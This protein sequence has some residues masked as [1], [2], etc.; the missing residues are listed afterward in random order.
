[1]PVLEKRRCPRPR[2]LLLA[3]SGALLLAGCKRPPAQT[4][5][6]AAAPT[7]GSTPAAPIAAAAGSAIPAPI[8]G[9][10]NVAFVYIG[11][12]GDGGWTY[13]HDQ[14]RQQL[15]KLVPDV[16][17]AY[18][19]S[20]AEGADAAQVIRGLA[21]KGFQLIV[22]TSFGY[23]DATEQVAREFPGTKFVHVSGFKSN[24]SNFGNLF[25]AM[26]SMKYLAGMIAGARAKADGRPRVGY[27]APFPIAEVIRLGNA[28]ALGVRASCPECTLTVRWIH[29]WFDP[30]R[31][32][33]AAESLLADG[34][35]VVVTGADS[36]GP[37]V[38]AAE[39]GRWGIGYDS[40]NACQAS[41]AR[42][43]TTPYWNW[44]AIYAD[45]VKQ[46]QAGTW[47]GGN[48]YRDVDSGIVGLA[49]F[50]E[51]EQPA[52]GVPAEVVPEVR[53]VLDRMRAGTF[54]R[55]DLFKGPLKNN[56]GAL[57]LA[58]GQ[59]LTQEDLEG[60]RG[61]AGRRDCAICMNWLVE[62]VSGELPK[63]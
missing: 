63:Q 59:V 41:P 7:P 25:G 3:A 21:R 2:W 45:L 35:G 52:P 20:V 28:L 55:F 48:D 32:K 12:V 36:T 11:P 44:G 6:G 14:G 22:T 33:E 16:H 50:M 19:E 56:Q 17:T 62:G 54:T 15:E 18:V 57:V 13:A 34:A 47:R 9:K 43:L 8:A 38:A 30:A 49:G 53:A 46:I 29:T 23:M 5:G 61:I 39:R 24:G 10:F 40:A 4:A 58:A 27:I 51:G 37:L 60:I 31:E 42:C 26:E 1:M